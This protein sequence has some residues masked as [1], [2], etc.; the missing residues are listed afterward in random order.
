MEEIEVAST[1]REAR[2]SLYERLCRVDCMTRISARE[3]RGVGPEY[4]KEKLRAFVEDEPYG[5][6]GGNLRRVLSA[7]VLRDGRTRSGGAVSA[8]ALVCA[9]ARAGEHRFHRL[10]DEHVDRSVFLAL[11]CGTGATEVMRHVVQK[12]VHGMSLVITMDSLRHVVP[13]YLRPEFGV[14]RMIDTEHAFATSAAVQEAYGRA[15]TEAAKAKVRASALKLLPEIL[16]AEEFTPLAECSVRGR[17]EQDVSYVQAHIV[18][19]PRDLQA[20]SFEELCKPDALVPSTRGR[21]KRRS[22]R[23]RRSP[24]YGA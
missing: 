5:E 1:T 20:R 9:P 21:Q 11:L 6:P 15:Y 10:R 2:A 4:L 16:K 24:P 13:Y 8:F 19:L 18:I 3:T 7:F 23:S 17:T 12:Y 22:R 14:A